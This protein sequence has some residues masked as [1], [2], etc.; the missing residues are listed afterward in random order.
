MRSVAGSVVSNGSDW[1]SILLVAIIL[2]S[3]LL[4]F[5]DIPQKMQLWRW[6]SFIRKRLYILERLE[7]DSRERAAR[8]LSKLKI[9]EP[10]RIIDN[11]ANN[12][13]IINPVNIEPTDIIKRLKHLLR[14]RDKAVKDYVNAV[15]KDVDDS[16]KRNTEVVLEVVSAI[17]HINKVVKHY[18]QLGLKFNNWILVMQLALEMPLI[19]KIMQAYHDSL[20]AFTKGLPI[21]D[22]AGPLVARKLLGANGSPEEVVEDTEVYKT[23]YKG[24]NVYVIKAK[25][26]GAT[27]GWPGDAV[28]KVI[29]RL[30]GKV[31]RIITVDAA[32]K[33]ESEKTGEVSYGVG[34]AIGDPG[35]EKIAIERVATK[36]SIPLEAIVIKMSD[37]EAINVMS[38][39]VYEGVKKAVGLVKKI[40][41]DKVPVGSNVIVVGIGNTVGIK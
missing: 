38:K 1:A 5:T 7:G 3:F 22:G 37:V 9:K 31:S 25:G 8:Y 27:V 34:A 17:S 36:Y 41:E 29:E 12:Y 20:E 26:P 15:L 23:E 28:E 6:A 24:R 33:L 40:I 32:L 21:G 2:T 13:F 10:E 14:T 18:F 19:L 30:N 11:F 35:P 4:N 39:E 16:I